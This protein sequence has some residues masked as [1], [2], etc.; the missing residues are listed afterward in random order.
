MREK[1]IA[2]D[3]GGVC[4]N[5]RHDL[6][7]KYF[8]F[9]NLREIPLE[10]LQAVEKFECG[11]IDDKEWL[12]EFRRATGGRFTDNEMIDGWNIIIG[13]DMDG[14]P[15]LMSELVDSGY[16]LI[17]FSDTSSV[18]LLE[19]YR[20][21]SFANLVTGGVFSF[22]VNAGKPGVAMY[23]AFEAQYG[24][25]YFYVDDKPENIQAGINHGWNS[26]QFLS[27]AAMRQ[28]LLN[29]SELNA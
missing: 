11:L 4:L 14:M 3:I 17:F 15:E 9:N 27:A 28:A 12:A 29:H 16:R 13:S 10:F 21:L 20:K 18:H 7:C 23:K 24:K 22:K 26:H 5:I 1:I 2:L 25:P 8:G 6:C 19:V